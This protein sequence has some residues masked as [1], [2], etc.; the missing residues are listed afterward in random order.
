MDPSLVWSGVGEGGR[1]DNL[2][3]DFFVVCSVVPMVIRLVL[4]V[5]SSGSVVLKPA[6]DVR[7]TR[8]SLSLS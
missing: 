1:W 5:L 2:P 8:G 7:E 3:R 6:T 4:K